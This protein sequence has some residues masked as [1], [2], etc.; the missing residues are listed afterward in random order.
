MSAVR[1]FAY[2]PVA[3]HAYVSVVSYS[4]AGATAVSPLEAASIVA[5]VN[6]GAPNVVST[7]TQL[8]VGPGVQARTPAW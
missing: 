8:P 4:S 1:L 7:G 2:Q 3:P 6:K 5:A